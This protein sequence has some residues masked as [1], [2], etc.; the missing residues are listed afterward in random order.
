MENLK[1]TLTENDIS[2]QSLQLQQSVNPMTQ[3]QN[4]L[5]EISLHSANINALDA[6]KSLTDDADITAASATFVIKSNTLLRLTTCTK[7]LIML[8][9]LPYLVTK[10]HMWY[11]EKPKIVKMCPKE[12]LKEHISN[13]NIINAK[14]YDYLLQTD[15]QL[16]ELEMQLKRSNDNESIK[17][18]IFGQNYLKLKD[19]DLLS[20]RLELCE[21]KG[22]IGIVMYWL[23][24]IAIENCITLSNLI[25]DLSKFIFNLNTKMRGLI[26][27]GPSDTGKS[28]FATLLYSIFKEHE[29][30]YFVHHL[31]MPL[32]LSC[33]H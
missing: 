27:C 14:H 30:G 29:V 19:E 4:K 28:L 3:P 32:L 16:R 17:K 2:I 8:R 6:H 33:N 15:E 23:K 12:N 31:K 20:E 24:V 5:L 26:L 11:P 7:P 25:K 10:K 9:T 22:R 18:I 21:E 13:L 1:K